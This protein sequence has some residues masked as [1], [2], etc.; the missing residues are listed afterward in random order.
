MDSDLYDEFGNY[1][2]PDLDSDD[3]EDDG[4]IPQQE[5][6]DDDDED[7][8]MNEPEVCVFFVNIYIYLLFLAR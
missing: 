3:D 6:E 5:E 7:E 4:L 2:G 8:E 1:I